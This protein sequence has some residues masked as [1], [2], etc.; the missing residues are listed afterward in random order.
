[1]GQLLGDNCT[2]GEDLLPRSVGSLAASWGGTARGGGGQCILHTPTQPMTPLFKLEYLLS[3]R[4]A[5][6]GSSWCWRSGHGQDLFAEMGRSLASNWR[7][8]MEGCGDSAQN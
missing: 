7:W 1:M 8:S 5:A 6:L 2:L 4:K 3:S